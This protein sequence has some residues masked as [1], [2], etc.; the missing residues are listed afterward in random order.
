[1]KQVPLKKA[2][3]ELSHYV[4]L[5]ATEDIIITKHGMPA[6][7]L[8]GIANADDLW[9]EMLL[10]DPAFKLRIAAARQSAREGRVHSLDEVAD[11]LGIP[12][13]PKSTARQKRSAAPN[14]KS[15]RK[16]RSLPTA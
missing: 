4:A 9:E 3:D 1:M 16:K 8:I 10:R 2:K 13:K 12:R 14:K 7:F 6:A 5:S 11:E 15:S